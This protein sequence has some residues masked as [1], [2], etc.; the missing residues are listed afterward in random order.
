MMRFSVHWYYANWGFINY[1]AL[2]LFISGADGL[3]EPQTI[4]CS[5]RCVVYTYYT[6]HTIS[7]T[8]QGNAEIQTDNVEKVERKG[9]QD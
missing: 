5:Q 3:N 8:T 6:L 1:Y 2:Y 4:Y 9:V 7:N